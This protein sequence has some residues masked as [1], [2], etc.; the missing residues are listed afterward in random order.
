MELKK[1]AAIVGLFKETIR[2]VNDNKISANSLLWKNRFSYNKLCRSHLSKQYINKSVS[3]S[4]V[5]S[6]PA[7]YG[8]FRELKFIVE[9][10]QQ[11]LLSLAE[12]EIKYSEE[13]SKIQNLGTD[14]KSTIDFSREHYGLYV[15]FSKLSHWP[16]IKY[17]V[18][19][20]S[21]GD[22][23]YWSDDDLITKAGDYDNF[24]H[25]KYSECNLHR[26]LMGRE[27]KSDLELRFPQ[28]LT[29]ARV[30][31][32]KKVYRSLGELVFGN[33]VHIAQ[34]QDDVIWQ[35]DTG[36]CRKN[37]NKS[38]TSDFYIKSLNLLIEISMFVENG[39]GS[40][41]KSYDLRRKEKVDIY[42]KM[43]I[44]C[45]FIDSSYFYQQGCFL[46]LKFAQAV[47]EEL[48]LLD[49]FTLNKTVEVDE[50]K[51]GFFESLDAKPDLTAEEY[52]AFLEE[53]F[54]LTHTAQLS[55]DKSFLRQI[56]K[57]RIDADKVFKLLTEK[58][59][60][61]RKIRRKDR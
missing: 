33:M 54:D 5:I 42:N 45:L 32:G 4:S 6:D 29:F 37:S 11:P 20:D 21:T 8:L 1:R 36:L 53:Q 47:V 40:R 55:Q 61:L 35:Y 30:G 23:F 19:K 14:L 10:I 50:S 28:Y 56:I 39:R 26:H 22:Y 15:H 12:V 27:L 7:T 43:D 3:R 38:M 18:F 44:K 57:L 49:Y 34:E 59:K 41:G 51:L 25:L 9:R 24:T 52:L 48:N 13:I 2:L 31:L 46:A 60:E 58:G 17:L 16:L